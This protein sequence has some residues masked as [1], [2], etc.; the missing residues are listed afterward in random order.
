MSPLLN[1]SR[2]DEA[3]EDSTIHA[4]SPPLSLGGLT[5]SRF[6]WTRTDYFTY[7]TDGNTNTTHRTADQVWT[8][9]YLGDKRTYNI[10]VSGTNPQNGHYNAFAK[11]HLLTWKGGKAKDVET[12]LAN[13]HE[14]RRVEDFDGYVAHRK[15]VHSQLSPVG[16]GQYPIQALGGQG[17]NA[18][19]TTE[20]STLSVVICDLIEPKKLKFAFAKAISALDPVVAG[21]AYP[22]VVVNFGDNNCVRRHDF[23]SNETEETNQITITFYCEARTHT[24]T[25]VHVVHCSG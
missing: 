20:D 19:S 3:P 2:E 25:T 21:T 22:H 7:F 14:S 15:K 4:C 12:K 1:Q 13:L 8:F 9:Q 5:M 16:Q 18:Y 23:M 6:Q 11:K 17:M 10:W 24:T